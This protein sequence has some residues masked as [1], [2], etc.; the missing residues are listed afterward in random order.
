MPGPE[1]A[2]MPQGRNDDLLLLDDLLGIVDPDRRSHAHD[3]TV[4]RGAGREVRDRR[5]G[6][7]PWRTA[8]ILP[9]GFMTVMRA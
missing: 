6:R 4:V 7:R 5:D 2:P 3:R 8:G 9:S 1:C